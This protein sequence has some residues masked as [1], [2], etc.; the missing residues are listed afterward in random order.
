MGATFAP[1]VLAGLHTALRPEKSQP[2]KTG[3][4]G[5][6]IKLSPKSREKKFPPLAP[7]G[8]KGGIFCFPAAEEIPG[9]CIQ[10][11]ACKKDGIGRIQFMSSMVINQ[12][13]HL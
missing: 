12:S 11:L 3:G 2:E 7:N 6:V 8:Q 10:F 9:L 4:R 5:N 13:N 1:K